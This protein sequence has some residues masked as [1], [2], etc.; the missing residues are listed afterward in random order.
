MADGR[1]REP[2]RD[3]P[4][5]TPSQG[6]NVEETA[7]RD[8]PNNALR[9]VVLMMVAVGVSLLMTVGLGAPDHQANWPEK[10]VREVRRLPFIS[11]QLAGSYCLAITL[12]PPPAVSCVR[13]CSCLTVALSLLR[14]LLLCSCCFLLLIVIFVLWYVS[15]TAAVPG[16]L[17]LSYIFSW[18]QTDDILVCMCSSHRVFFQHQKSRALLCLCYYF[19]VSYSWQ[20]VH[21][22]LAPRVFSTAIDTFVHHSISVFIVTWVFP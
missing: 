1:P 22:F 12:C 5:R 6:V 17:L 2:W 11:L 13:C 4:K 8:P 14:A 9:G 20:C 19:C 7:G 16:W 15:R 10:R 18:L 3:S 21:A